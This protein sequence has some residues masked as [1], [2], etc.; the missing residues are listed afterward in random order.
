MKTV[1]NPCAC[2]AIFLRNTKVNWSTMDMALGDIEKFCRLEKD[3][4]MKAEVGSFRRPITF[5]CVRTEP[6]EFDY[7]CDT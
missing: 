2:L 7:L 1:T 3:R 5:C 6:F 4:I